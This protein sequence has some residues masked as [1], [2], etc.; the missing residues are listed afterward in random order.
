MTRSLSG[1]LT[2]LVT[3]FDRDENIDAEALRRVVDRSIEAGVDGVV[4]GGSTGDFATLTPSERRF[5]VD[6]VVEHTAGRVPVI[7]QTGAMT[8]RE[9]IQ[10][11]RAAEASGAD[12]LM[13]V[14]PWYDLLSE[15]E[16]FAYYAEVASSVELPIMLYNIPDL[17]GFNHSPEFVGRLAEALPNVKYIKDSSGNWDQNLRLIHE[18]GDRVGTFVGWDPFAYSALLEGATGVMAGTANVVPAELVSV[19]NRI[20]SGDV[21]GATAEWKDLY[22]VISSICNA[23]FNAAVKAGLDMQGLSVGASRRPAASLDAENAAKI[24]S[25]LSTLNRKRDRM[26]NPSEQVRRGDGAAIVSDA[27]L[28]PLNHFI[29]GAFVQQAPAGT[30]T[31][32]DPATGRAICEV[33]SGTAA[34]VDAAVT[35]AREALPAWRRR[36]PKDRSTVLNQIADRIEQNADLLARLEQANAGKPRMVAEDDIAGSVDTFRFMAGACRAFT[37]LGSAEYVEDHT[38]FILREA[39]GVVGAVVPWNYPL[40]M[41][42]W[43]LAPILAAGNTVVIKP[44]EQTPLTLLKFAELVQDLLPAG[45]LNVVT[46][47]GPTVGAAISEHPGIDLVALTGSVRAGKEVATHAGD[48]LKRVHLE[49]G[50]KAP[51]VIFADADLAAAAE[52]IRAAGYWNSGQECGAGTR[53]LVHESVADEFTRLLVDQV[54][55]LVVGTPDAGDDVEIGPVVSEAHFERVKAALEQAIADGATPALGGAPLEG[56]GYFIAPTVLTNVAAGSRASQEEIFGPVVTVETFTD[57]DEALRRANETPYGLAASVW[58]GDAARSM[59]LPREFDFGTVWV[60]CHLVL[61]NEVPW[62]GFKGSG[63]GRDL[64]VYALNDFS[65]TKHVQV[66]HVR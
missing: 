3:P 50:G 21:V 8:V 28:P 43:K 48:T 54:K 64:S 44:S 33:A 41:A 7:A 30:D 60:N 47:L 32:V 46:G 17:T 18:L 38:S 22:P 39:V 25:A 11:S 4:A 49:L 59:A 42:A 61:S 52:S 24:Q 19:K 2:A 13:L 10:H 35:A 51:L 9:A 57:E 29:N 55:T 26:S 66:S 20:M 31:L 63:Y 37:E 5:L 45:V 36:T 23:P 14:T 27:E 15:D 34:D 40:L 58:T 6:T 65:R 1:V 16:V 62:G 12:V 53:V 56:D